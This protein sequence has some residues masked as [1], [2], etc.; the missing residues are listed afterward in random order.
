MLEKL[1]MI[2]RVRQGKRFPIYLRTGHSFND[3]GAGVSYE[4]VCCLEDVKDNKPI[5]SKPV[6]IEKRRV[7]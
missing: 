3:N 6:W 7:S 1:L 5:Y 4:R 2:E